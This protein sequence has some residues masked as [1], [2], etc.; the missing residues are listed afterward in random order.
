MVG[1]GGTLFASSK[2]LS[3]ALSPSDGERESA[4]VRGCAQ[5]CTDLGVAAQNKT[6]VADLIPPRRCSLS[7]YDLWQHFAQP[8]ASVQHF[9]HVAWSLQQLP[10]HFIAD[11]W[12]VAQPVVRK[13]P[14]TATIASVIIVFMFGCLSPWI[15]FVADGTHGCQRQI[16]SIPVRAAMQ[17]SPASPAGRTR[18]WRRGSG[19]RCH[20]IG[21][22]REQWLRASARV[23]VN[24][25]SS[26]KQIHGVASDDHVF[27]W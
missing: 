20:S 11:L 9:M 14:A 26:K 18:G 21:T 8:A 27:R 10:S 5:S 16:T 4:A 1:R 2:P 24:P 22:L 25:S 3:P 17:K 13:I 19:W 23:G 12:P 7:A 15:G 6:A